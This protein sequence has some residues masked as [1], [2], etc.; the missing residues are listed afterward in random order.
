MIKSI[1]AAVALCVAV[2][3]VG[4]RADDRV[5]KQDSKKPVASFCTSILFG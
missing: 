2:L 4:F 1:I 5:P 3:V